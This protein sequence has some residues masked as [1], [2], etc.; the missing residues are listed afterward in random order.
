MDS[1]EY[2]KI[3][4][5][6]M[7]KVNKFKK[8]IYAFLCGGMIG[9]SAEAIYKLIVYYFKVSQSTGFII[10]SM[11]VVIIT[12]ILTGIGVF[13]N[14][15]TFF[16]AGLIVPT[17]GFAHSVV[18]GAIDR[19]NEGFIMGIA[20]GL[21]RLCGCVIISGVVSSFIFAI[22]GWLIYG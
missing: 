6:H 21:F 18:S 17:T 20:P 11:I 9:L 7:P 4:K 12:A 10:V 19:K 2:R 22:I 3:I 8:A 16:E 14:F 15:V 5:R 1:M 13:D